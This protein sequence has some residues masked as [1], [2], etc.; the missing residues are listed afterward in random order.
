[1][2][3]AAKQHLRTLITAAGLV[4]LALA[5]GG[6]GLG[7][8]TTVAVSAVTVTA[9][10]IGLG[11]WPRARP[12]RAAWITLAGLGLLTLMAGLSA[13]WADSAE[14]AF[15]EF[16]RDL[17]YL[18]L[19][20]L[21]IAAAR[22][23]D[24]ARWG[25]GLALGIA[26]VATL[27][28]GQRCFP[29]AFPRDQLALF[30]PGV[31]TRLT[32]PLGYWNGLAILVGLGPPLL[33]R[34]ALEARQ[35]Y[36]RGLALAA[37]PVI[38]SVIYLTSSRGGV[39]AAVFGMATFLALTHRRVAACAAIA[40]GLV[41]TGAAIA[42]L[43]A[44]SQLVDGPLLSSQAISQGR[45]AA[46]IVIA[47]AALCAAAW[48]FLS[49]PRTLRL[50][51]P[52]R[53]AAALTAVC[54]IAAV[55]GAAAANP[56][57]RLHEFKQPPGQPSATNFV[58]SHLLSGTG[59]GRWQFWGSAWKE[60]ESSPLVGRG[61]GSFESWW[62]RH[63][64]ITYYVRDAHSLYLQ[65][66]GELGLAGLV[67]LVL[68]FGP[69]LASAVQRARTAAAADR[70]SVAALAGAFAAFLIGAGLDWV[71][72]LSVVGAVGIVCLG[73]LTG[74]ASVFG[75]SAPR[76]VAQPTVTDAPSLPWAPPP[77]QSATTRDFGGSRPTLPRLG[78]ILLVAAVAVGTEGLP[79][80]TNREVSASE[81]AVRRGDLVAG[82]D[83]ALNATALWPWASSPQL[84]L[85]LVDE[86]AGDLTGAQRALAQA[87]DDDPT[88]WRLWIVSTRLSVEGGNVPAARRA[89]A[90][91]RAL[92]P[93][94]ILLAIPPSPA[95]VLPIPPPR[96]G[97]RS[98]P[99]SS[100]PQ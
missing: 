97:A 2:P 98:S 82:H 61:A 7:A 4:A 87:V 22:R 12:P 23:G 80:L 17:M 57:Q 60:F 44:R 39:A 71:W 34:G 33:L 9:I 99:L 37:F 51:L 45:S 56:A 8:R 59:S 49:G 91:A 76:P 16:D 47:C 55:A 26:V 86:A 48:G 89:L 62:A 83:H 93:K 95:G 14:L 58:S 27:A 28:L 1:M 78:L 100:P 40:L 36:M 81:A 67:A 77:P 25:D 43:H 74:P 69:G 30:L 6:Y 79:W 92:N 63:A 70:T 5:G 41:A 42:A 15:L 73:V 24:A 18:A 75:A 94:N 64:P 96:A 29:H 32:Y 21:A 72:Q 20:A 35:P 66:L 88:D 11:L 3:T 38:G 46:L 84:Q 90:R 50:R 85:A 68:G 13:A 10:A 54:I 31:R 52:P 19:L 53:A 65:T